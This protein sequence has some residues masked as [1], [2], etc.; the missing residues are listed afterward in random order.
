M[1]FHVTSRL[2]HLLFLLFLFNFLFF[3]MKR[4]SNRRPLLLYR[5]FRLFFLKV[6]RRRLRNFLLVLLG[7][8]GDRFANRTMDDLSF[9]RFAGLE[10]AADVALFVSSNPPDFSLGSQHALLLLRLGL[11]LE[12]VSLEVRLLLFLVLLRF[13]LFR[14]D[15]SF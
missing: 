6:V 4:V 13:E 5:R 1:K 7:L 12:L 11:S 8:R 15:Q 2:D 10:S 14:I 9:F 3:L